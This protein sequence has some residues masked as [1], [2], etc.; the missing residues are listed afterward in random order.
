[1]R[2]TSAELDG[3]GTAALHALVYRE[4]MPTLVQ[5]EGRE[6]AER[7]VLR[8]KVLGGLGPAATADFLQ[9]LIAATPAGRDREHLRLDVAIDPYMG[10][11]PGATPLPQTQATLDALLAGDG[12]TAFC[13]PCNSAH[14]RVRYLQFDRT[15][16]RFVSMVDATVETVTARVPPGATVALLATAH[17]VA[18]GLYQ[19]AFE[20]AGLRVVVP[21]PAWQAVVNTVVYGGTHAGRLHAGIKGG[22]DGPAATALLQEVVD[23]MH[24]EHAPAAICLSCTELPLV[25]GPQRTGVVKGDSHGV[26]I[27]NSTRALAHVFVRECLRLQARELLSV[28]P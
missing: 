21:P 3:L 28:T 20:F 15:R 26:P 22:D 7:R 19:A 16:V 14:A 10:Q 5:R 12:P 25:F 8:F 6:V 18:S 2:C 1:M 13:L 27:V 11:L 24:A 23:A 4:L 9:E 17:M